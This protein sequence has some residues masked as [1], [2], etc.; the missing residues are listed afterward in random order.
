MFLYYAFALVIESELRFP[1]L[2]TYGVKTLFVPDVVIRF[3]EVSS[4]GLN[5][6]RLTSLFYQANQCELW[7]N[8][9]NVALFLITDGQTITINPCPGVDEAS[10]RLFLLGSCMGALLMQRDLFLLHGNGVK[11]GK[12][13]VSFV[14]QSGAGKSTLSGAF[15]KR[16]YSVLADDICAINGDGDVLPGFPQ[17]KLWCDAAKKLNISTAGL[18]KIR[19]CVEKFAVPLGAQFYEEALPLRVVYHLHSHNRDDFCFSGIVGMQKL[20]PLQRNSYRVNYI[21]GFAKTKM[22]LGHCGRIANQ[23]ALV[24]IKRPDTGFKLDELVNLVER[25]LHAKGYLDACE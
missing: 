10:L 7:L 6:P 2:K 3:G 4:T 1:E 8:V 21:K 20:T 18:R 15:F 9:P 24:N 5:C 25:D 16:G 22:H 17:I 12:V 11:V 14:G 23:I 19:P 13:C